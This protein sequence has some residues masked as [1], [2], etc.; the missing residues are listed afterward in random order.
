M[1]EEAGEAVRV[2]EPPDEYRADHQV[3]VKYWEDILEVS[4]AISRAT[5]NRDTVE[6]RRQF[7]ESGVVACNAARSL[8]DAIRPIL[9]SHLFPGPGCSSFE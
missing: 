3:I 5:V 2:L 6:Q 4:R 9:G 7:I 1:L 8:S